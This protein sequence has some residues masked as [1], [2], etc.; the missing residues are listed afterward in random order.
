[1]RAGGKVER[2]ERWEWEKERRLKRCW[3]EG[4]EK[5]GWRECRGGS[6]V[7]GEG[8]ERNKERERG[9]N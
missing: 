7:E 1:M 3:R 9:N 2:E 6:V 5:G 4:G 8:G